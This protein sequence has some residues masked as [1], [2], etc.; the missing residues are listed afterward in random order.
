MLPEI[1]DR[2]QYVTNCLRGKFFSN[3]RDTQASICFV[4]PQ[5]LYAKFVVF[6]ALFEKV[7][8]VVY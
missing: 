5:R 4:I 3:N 1:E 2:V 8:M 7:N 6:Y